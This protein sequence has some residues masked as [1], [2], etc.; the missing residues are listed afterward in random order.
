MSRYHQDPF[1]S[2]HAKNMKINPSFSWYYLVVTCCCIGRLPF[3]QGT[4]GS[5]A[6]YPIYYWAMQHYTMNHEVISFLYTVAAILG[7]LGCY[8][9]SLFQKEIKIDDHSSIVIDELVGQ[10]LALAIAYPWLR[11]IGEETMMWHHLSVR[12]FIF[13]ATFLMFRYYD[14]AKPLIIGAIDNLSR[15]SVAVMLDDVLAGAAA[16]GSA[17]LAYLVGT[18]L[19]LL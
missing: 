12:D 15:Y 1:V 19:G 18:Q 4:F 9:I 14:I 7:V 11:V 16:G 6:A 3:A 17:Y 10:L 13:T 2:T 8:A 5:L